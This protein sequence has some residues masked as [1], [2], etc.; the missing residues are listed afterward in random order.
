M[1]DLLC[2]RH[3]SSAA[4]PLFREVLSLSVFFMCLLVIL[5][6]FHEAQY[7]LYLRPNVIQKSK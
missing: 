6:Q 7:L 1:P 4:L 3:G 2:L 5:L